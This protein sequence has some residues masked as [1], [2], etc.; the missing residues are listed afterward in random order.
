MEEIMRILNLIHSEPNKTVERLIE[1]FS[2]EDECAVE[3]LYQEDIDWD[4]LVDDIFS[5]DKVICWW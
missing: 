4:R 3:E 2:G 1:Y 5:Y